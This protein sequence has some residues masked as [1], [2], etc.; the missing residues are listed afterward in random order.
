MGG[1]SKHYNSYSKC[2]VHGKTD[3]SRIPQQ[4][5]RFIDPKKSSSLSSKPKSEK[6]DK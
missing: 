4:T 6:G 1:S 3:C 5:G 2:Q